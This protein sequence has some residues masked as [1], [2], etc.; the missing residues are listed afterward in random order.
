MPNSQKI[1]AST[2]APSGKDRQVSVEIFQ[3][4]LMTTMRVKN[5]PLKRG[6]SKTM[7]GRRDPFTEQR[8]GEL[9]SR[10]REEPRINP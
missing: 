8:A 9:T 10:H 2:S 1:S 7:R 5:Y 3:Q 4:T 6:G